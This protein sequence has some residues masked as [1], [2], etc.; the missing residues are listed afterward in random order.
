MR[1]ALA[2]SSTA[3]PVQWH[4]ASPVSKAMMLLTGFIPDLSTEHKAVRGRNRNLWASSRIANHSW[5]FS[6]HKSN[7]FR[8]SARRVDWVIDK[9]DEYIP[10]IAT[11]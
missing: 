2:I 10:V 5:G 4:P 9:G 11:K 7:Y 8:Y 6:D 1:P 3:I